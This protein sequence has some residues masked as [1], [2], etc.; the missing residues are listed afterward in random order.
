MREA[1]D[2][3]DWCTHGVPAHSV[4]PMTGLAV[5][6][7]VEHHGGMGDLSGKVVGSRAH[8]AELSTVGR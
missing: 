3:C 5:G 8:C 7:H 1:L 4:S 2:H 6:L